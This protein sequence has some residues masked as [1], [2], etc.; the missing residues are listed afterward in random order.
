MKG[1]RLLPTTISALLARESAVES[2]KTTCQVFSNLLYSLDQLWVALPR[3]VQAVSA[4]LPP[5][6]GDKSNWN[7]NPP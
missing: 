1:P 3:T 5:L 4:T 6:Q 2:E 7:W